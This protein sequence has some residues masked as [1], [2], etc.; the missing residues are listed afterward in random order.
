NVGMEEHTIMIRQGPGDYNM[1]YA[2]ALSARSQQVYNENKDRAMHLDLG[3]RAE[4]WE[5]TVDDFTKRGLDGKEETAVSKRDGITVL[6]ALIVKKD[7]PEATFKDVLDNR[8]QNPALTEAKNAATAR[9]LEAYAEVQTNPQKLG[10]V[11]ADAAKAYSEINIQREVKQFSAAG[12]EFRNP[13]SRVE[14]ISNMATVAQYCVDADYVINSAVKG[15]GAWLPFTAD[16]GKGDSEIANAV[17]ESARSQMSFDDQRKYQNAAFNKYQQDMLLGTFI[18]CKSQLD[19]IG[20]LDRQIWRDERYN[21]ERV[22]APLFAAA[23]K[24]VS[25]IM[26][27]DKSLHDFPLEAAAEVEKTGRVAKGSKALAGYSA[28]DMIMDGI[29]EKHREKIEEKVSKIDM[30]PRKPDKLNAW[31]RFWSKMGFYKDTVREHNAAT[32]NYEAYLKNEEARKEAGA[33]VDKKEEAVR[34][35]S[36]NNLQNSLNSDRGISKPAEGLTPAVKEKA[37]EIKTPSKKM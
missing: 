28:I 19:K 34:K 4:T 6:T 14:F 24:A 8:N 21:I 33:F 23:D 36:L 35:V 11:I 37:P 25:V 17:Y 2:E 16:T 26:N 22:D 13:E 9:I 12:E 7:N 31:V 30:E 3:D 18:D 20:D 5:A 10:S 27:N 32:A 15:R 1:T 29:E